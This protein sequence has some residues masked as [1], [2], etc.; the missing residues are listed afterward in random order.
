MS[1][2]FKATWLISF[3][4]V[5]V[6]DDDDDDNEEEVVDDD[7]GKQ[8]IDLAHYR[9]KHRYVDIAFLQIFLPCT[10]GGP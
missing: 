6:L 2:Y 7:A 10:V 5:L 3:F 9:R 8:R 1:F 4:I